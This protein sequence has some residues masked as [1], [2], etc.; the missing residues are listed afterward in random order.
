M[1][2]NRRRQPKKLPKFLTEDE[3]TALIRVPNPRY[4]TGERNRLLMIVMLDAGLRLSEA[5]SSPLA[6]SRLEH[7]PPDGTAG[8]GREGSDRV[9]R[10]GR[11]RPRPIVA[12]TAG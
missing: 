4:P 7:G 8:Q 5:G 11:N 3:V 2:A 10:S 6:G 9:A 12:T 1:N